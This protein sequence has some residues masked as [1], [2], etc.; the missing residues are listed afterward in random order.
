MAGKV[1]KITKTEMAKKLGISRSSLYY[2]SKREL[3][4]REVKLQIES[5]MTEN[6]YYGHKR[7]ALALKLNKK[8][9][10][11]VMKKYGIRPLRKKAK[12]LK[13]RDIGKKHVPFNNLIEK[14]CPIRKNVVWVC[15]FTYIKYR[16]RFIYFAVVIDMFTREVLGFGI[17]RFHNKALVLG[18]F[19]DAVKTEGVKPQFIHSDQGSEYDSKIYTEVAKQF[20]IQMSMSRKGSPWENGFV[21]S[22]FGKFKQ[23]LGNISEFKELV[24]LVEKIYKQVWYYNNRRIHT[25]LKMSPVEFKRCR[26]LLFKK[27]GT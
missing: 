26:D 20:N 3:I 15:D 22:F 8:R 16:G 14:F 6:P 19:L 11:R 18:A 9:I 25:S 23:E 13:R 7:I 4:D 1:K 2:K 5:V 24:F 17:S 21:E 27:L 12:F 10:L